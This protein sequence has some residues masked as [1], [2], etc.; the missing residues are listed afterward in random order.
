MG[1]KKNSSSKETP[2]ERFAS[3]GGDGKD[4]TR[5]APGGGKGTQRTIKVKGS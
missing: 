5:L 2:V 4:G 1:E 3:T